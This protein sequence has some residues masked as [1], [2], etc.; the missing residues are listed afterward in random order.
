MHGGR[1][2]AASSIFKPPPQLSAWAALLFVW[3]ESARDTT[4]HSCHFPRGKSGFLVPSLIDSR[5]IKP[6]PTKLRPIDPDLVEHE[7]VERGLVEHGLV[8]RG[9][10]RTGLG[11]VMKR[12]PLIEA[13]TIDHPTST[14]TR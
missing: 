14:S 1:R 10:R 2:K 7:L 13:A 9:L 11:R 5:P 4:K 3:R 12:A 6:R 8:D